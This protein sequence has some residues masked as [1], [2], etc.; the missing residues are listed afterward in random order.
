MSEIIET[1][2][3]VAVIKGQLREFIPATKEALAD[4]K[5]EVSEIRGQL[6]LVSREVDGQKNIC[7]IARKNLHK[8]VNDL[9]DRHAGIQAQDI[10]LKKKRLE[11]AG[12]ALN[13]AFKIA[14]AALLVYIATRMNRP[15]VIDIALP[16]IG[17]G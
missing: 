8:R 13:V 1:R 9:Q 11:L 16:L 3:D 15:D 10:D 6:T 17:A 5:K 14:S 2:N 7:E 12:K 4:I